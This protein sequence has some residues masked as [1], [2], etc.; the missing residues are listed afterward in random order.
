MGLFPTFVGKLN[1]GGFYGY[2]GNGTG[3][4]ETEICVSNKTAAPL[5]FVWEPAAKIA[6]RLLGRLGMQLLCIYSRLY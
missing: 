3:E 1:L 6:G 5:I 4:T 2:K